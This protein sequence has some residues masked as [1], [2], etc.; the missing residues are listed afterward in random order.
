MS[1]PEMTALLKGIE[2]FIEILW[3]YGLPGVLISLVAVPAF[4]MLVILY[5]NHLATVRMEKSQEAFRESIANI[6][7]SNRKDTGILLEAYRLDTHEIIKDVGVKHDKIVRLHETAI[8]QIKSAEQHNAIL[9]TIVV[10]NTQ[11]MEQLKIAI[12]TKG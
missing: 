6:T 8:A 9:H 5:M 2:S 4:V 3:Q 7:E 1:P 10:N 11:A 12:R